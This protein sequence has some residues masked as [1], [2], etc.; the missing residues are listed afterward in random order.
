MLIV[1]IIF[2]AAAILIFVFKLFLAYNVAK[3]PL[4]GGGVPTIDEH[5]EAIRKEFS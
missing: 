4:G 3:D 1:G 5:G 2:C